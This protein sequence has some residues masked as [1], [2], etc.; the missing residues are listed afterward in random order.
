[1]NDPCVLLNQVNANSKTLFQTKDGGDK[2][3]E[4][5]MYAINYRPFKSTPSYSMFGALILRDSM[6]RPASSL[7]GLF[8]ASTA[9]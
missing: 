9:L 2:K 6:F 8:A 4:S 7:C 1:M 3:Y 5:G